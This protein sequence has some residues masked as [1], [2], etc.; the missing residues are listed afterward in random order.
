MTLVALVVFTNWFPKPKERGARDAGKTPEPFSGVVRG[1]FGALWFTVT[2]PV[3]V[4]RI[5]GVNVMKMLQ[6]DRAATLFGETGQVELEVWAK[7]PETAMDTMVSGT[8]W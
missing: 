4:P 3:R 6:L 8:V 5:V 2:A 1:E 7:S